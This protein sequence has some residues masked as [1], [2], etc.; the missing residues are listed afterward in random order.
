MI[1]RF[2]YLYLVQ[3]A[4]DLIVQKKKGSVL[5]QRLLGMKFSIL[6]ISMMKYLAEKRKEKE[7]GG[8]MTPIYLFPNEWVGT[9]NSPSEH[10]ASIASTAIVSFNQ[11]I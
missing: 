8:Q 11:R 9:C 1:L 6:E 10:L 2:H 7:V 3:K 4:S 5:T